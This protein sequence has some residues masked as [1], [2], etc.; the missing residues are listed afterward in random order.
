MKWILKSYPTGWARLAVKRVKLQRHPPI[1]PWYP[2]ILQKSRQSNLFPP[3]CWA[4]A[5]EGGPLR[6]STAINIAHEEYKSNEV[7]G[8][9]TY[10]KYK[11]VHLLEK[12]ETLSNFAY[13]LCL[14]SF[15]S[16]Y[17]SHATGPLDWLS[18]A[19]CR[20][21]KDSSRRRRTCKP[22]C[23]PGNPQSVTLYNCLDVK[24]SSYMQL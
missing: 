19:Q 11:L 9:I 16:I 24:R 14:I 12:W 20:F 18:S 2:V 15:F 23:F 22:S 10:R 4:T 21:K 17:S 8:D 3:R 1:I 6:T 7:L 5:D 13:K